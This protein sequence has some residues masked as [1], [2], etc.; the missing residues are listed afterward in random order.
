MSGT[1]DVIDAT[2]ALGNTFAKIQQ[3][4]ADNERRRAEALRRLVWFVTDA[5]L[6]QLVALPW[7]FGEFETAN[8][9]MPKFVRMPCRRCGMETNWSGQGDSDHKI[10]AL[11]DAFW[12]CRNCGREAVKI[13]FRWE[14]RGAETCFEKVGRYPKA[15]INPPK[16]LAK[17]LGSHLNFYRSGLTLRQHGYGLGAL[18]YFRRIVEETTEALLDLI[19]NLIGGL[20][21]EAERMAAIKNAKR[22]QRFEDK[23]KIAADALP[24]HLR[25]G[26]RNPLSILF[27]L[28]SD[29]LHSRTDQEAIEVVDGINSILGYLFTELKTHTEKREEYVAALDSSLERLSKPKKSSD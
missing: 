3:E 7:A 18:V 5:P 26:G 12:L 14:T 8:D 22:A 27:R 9:L 17:A 23:V 19:E 13:Y 6:Y 28:L 10:G 20:D 1:K 29:H 21:G 11:G 15:E 2:N 4:R 16:E 24:A 25:M